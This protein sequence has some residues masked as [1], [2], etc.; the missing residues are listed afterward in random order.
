MKKICDAGTAGDIHGRMEALD[1]S[2]RSVDHRLRAVE[3]RLSAK[4]PGTDPDLIVIDDID[5]EDFQ[6][7]IENLGKSL[8]VLKRSIEEARNEWNPNEISIRINN[9]QAEVSKLNYKIAEGGNDAEVTRSTQVQLA[10]TEHRITKL[11]NLNRITI[12]KIKVPIEF[13]GL[14][15]AIVLIASGY[16]IS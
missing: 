15:A 16:L 1:Q 13:S 3:K 11:E 14:L 9:L 8:E 2:I 10:D 5:K 6:S 7:E 4:S 12:G